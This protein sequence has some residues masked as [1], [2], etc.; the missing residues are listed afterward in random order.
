VRRHVRFVQK[1]VVEHVYPNAQIL[2]VLILHAVII[3][4]GVMVVHHVRILFALAKITQ[5]GLV[6]FIVL[7]VEKDK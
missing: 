2:V 1:L 3:L 7:F 5:L 6:S 4:V